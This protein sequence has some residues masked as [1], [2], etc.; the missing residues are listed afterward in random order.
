M[1]KTVITY[2]F[3]IRKLFLKEKQYL[4]NQFLLMQCGLFKMGNIY[5]K[6]KKYLT[7]ST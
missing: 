2:L 5:G 7:I 6:K 4:N 1:N 3:L